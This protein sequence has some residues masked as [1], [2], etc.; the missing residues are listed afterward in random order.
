[1]GKT[2]L[3]LLN[4]LTSTLQICQSFSS[5]VLPAT[6][7]VMPSMQLQ[8]PTQTWRSL[9]L[10]ATATKEPRLPHNIPRLDLCT[11][12][13]TAPSYS[14]PRLQ[15]QTL[16]FIAPTAITWPLQMLSLLDLL[17]VEERHTSSTPL[18][19]VSCLSRTLRTTP[20]VSSEKRPL[21]IGTTLVRSLQS[22]M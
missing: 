1:M 15:M 9:H 14:P 22:L 17:E 8:M 3:R 18:E 6:S 10:F 13:L 12:R 20:L 11:V 21:M 4:I 19:L 16:F 5:Q 7:E 2:L